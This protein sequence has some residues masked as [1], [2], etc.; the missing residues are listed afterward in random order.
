MRPR[1]KIQSVWVLA[2]KTL[3]AVALLTSGCRV[4]YVLGD[5]G[6]FIIVQE[7]WLKRPAKCWEVRNAS[8][9]TSGYRHSV[10]W[11]VDYGEVVL[12]GEFILVKVHGGDFE[13]AHAYIGTMRERC[14]NGK[15]LAPNIQETTPMVAQFNAKRDGSCE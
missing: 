4:G 11:L 12:E 7:D 15:Y 14:F 1:S 10:R 13:G 9:K 2:M 6:D 8:V 3:I 5:D